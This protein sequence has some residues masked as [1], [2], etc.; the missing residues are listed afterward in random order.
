MSFTIAGWA[1]SRY[2]QQSILR[3]LKMRRFGAMKVPPSIRV[4][5]ARTRTGGSVRN[6][7]ASRTVSGRPSAR[8]E[9]LTCPLRS[10]IPVIW[11]S[12]AGETSRELLQADLDRSR[13]NLLRFIRLEFEMSETLYGLLKQ[14]ASKK[15]RK[16]LR[17]DVRKARVSI[18]HFRQKLGTKESD[19][20]IDEF[21]R[22]IDGFL[23]AN[24][25]PSVVKLL[26]K[27][28]PQRLRQLKGSKQ[29]R[30][31]KNREDAL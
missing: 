3:G 16:R 15:H 27:R 21:L 14:T 11:Y 23:R 30:L 1:Q 12:M 28:L 10:S 5:K 2:F 4:G 19:A 31:T 17:K 26:L 9:I 25:S 29:R 8:A 7:L 20:E 22:K 18:V 6:L 13:E 24:R